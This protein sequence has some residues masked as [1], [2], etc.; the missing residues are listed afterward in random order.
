M[1]TE[2][3]KRESSIWKKRAI[4]GFIFASLL[5]AL[6]AAPLMAYQVTKGDTLWDISERFLQNPFFWPKY[7]VLN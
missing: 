6:V 1:K 7:L 5:C 4:F 2:M 3:G